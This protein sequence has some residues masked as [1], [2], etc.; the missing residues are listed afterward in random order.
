[1][2]NLLAGFSAEIW[3]ERYAQVC[4]RLFEMDEGRHESTQIMVLALVMLA[5]ALFGLLRADKENLD[6][7]P[8]M[9]AD[10]EKML[11]LVMKEL[12]NPELMEGGEYFYEQLV[13]IVSAN[14]DCFG[15]LDEGS[16]QVVGGNGYKSYGFFHDNYVYI[17][18]KVFNDFLK[19]FSKPGKSIKSLLRDAKLIEADEG[20]FTKQLNLTFSNCYRPRMVCMKYGEEKSA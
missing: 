13:D 15:F 19:Q 20:R 5:D 9:L 14:Y 10:S 8:S 17:N 6:E 16:G 11:V 7:L 18:S 1:M 2:L 3:Q 4:D 12:E